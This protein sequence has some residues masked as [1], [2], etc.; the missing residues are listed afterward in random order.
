MKKEEYKYLKQ[1]KR[2]KKRRQNEK[3]N[4]IQEKFRNIFQNYSEERQ[5]LKAPMLQMSCISQNPT[6]N[7]TLQKKIKRHHL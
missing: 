7:A 1:R 2:L 5:A 4:K 6:Y 3:I